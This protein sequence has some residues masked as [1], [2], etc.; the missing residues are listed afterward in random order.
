MA[1]ASMYGLYKCTESG[2]L[3]CNPLL[4]LVVGYLGSVGIGTLSDSLTSSS[5]V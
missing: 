5:S 2:R 4:L 3:K 1:T